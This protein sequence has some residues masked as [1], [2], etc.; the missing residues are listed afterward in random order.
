MR[1]LGKKFALA[2]VSVITAVSSFGQTTTVNGQQEVINTITTAVPFMRIV[3]D[4]RSGGMGNV[5]IAISPDVNGAQS[6]GAKMAFLDDDFGVGLSFTPWLKSLVNDIYLANLTGF[7]RVKNVQTIHASLRY[8]SLGDIQFTDNDGNNTIK[9]RPQELS[10]DLG[11]SRRLGKIASVGATL[12]FIY[13]NLSPGGVGGND[14]KPAM[15]GA[16]DI[17][18]MV[19]KHWDPKKG[20]LSHELTWGLCISNI[21]NKVSYTSNSTKDFLP[22]NIGMGFGYK[23]HLDREDKYVVGAYLDLNK[24]MVPTPVTQDNLYQKKADGSY[25]LNS[26]GGKLIKSEYDTNNNGVP[27]YK[28]QSVVQ[29]MFTSFGD[30]SAIEELR[31]ISTGVGAEFMYKKMFGVRLGYFYEHPTKG[32]RNY[33]TVGA[34]VKYSVATLHASYLVPTSNQRNPLDNTFSFSLAFQFNKAAM[35]KKAAEAAPENGA[36]APVEITPKKQGKKT[37]KVK[38][39]TEP[40]PLMQESPK[41]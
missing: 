8:F 4:T 26:A 2:A 28:E 7:Y 31:E 27:D 35:K 11:Y 9:V 40:A 5:G 39:E 10:V 32:N 16:A 33:M 20:D 19:D 25:I 1:L 12:R 24:L 37:A 30:A 22:T 14:V 29:G 17:S 3:N 41:Q 36:P 23:L 18:V 13:S 6:N 15:A 38:E 21:G 34:T